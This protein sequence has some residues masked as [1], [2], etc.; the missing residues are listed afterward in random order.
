MPESE[1]DE[2]LRQEF[3]EWAVAGRGSD[4]ERHHLNIAAQTIRR[5][6]LQSGERVLD[7]SCGTGWAARL[8]ARLVAEG[9]VGF[10]QVVGLDI[11][12]EMIARARE[13]S[14]DFENL[15]FVWGSAEQIPWDENYFDKV[16]SIEAFYYFPDQERVLN[17][18]F[19]V[20][21]PR[22]RLFILINLYSDNPH[23]RRCAEKLK[24]PVHMR[25]EQEYAAMLQRCLF[26]EVEV[27]HIPD[28]TPTPDDYQNEVFTVQE[29]REIKRIGALL[30]TASKPNLSRLAGPFD[31]LPSLRAG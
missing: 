22:G 15:L 8:V 18:L 20:M 6:R 21:A 9:P 24:V 23:S 17:E 1:N 5:M 26:E 29:M 25:S 28:E 19:R 11:S 13:A 7:L 27:H 30:L 4:M 10:G 14:R 2:R 16:L 31:S 12:D 3:N